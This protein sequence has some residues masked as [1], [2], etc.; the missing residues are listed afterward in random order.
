M[1]KDTRVRSFFPCCSCERV[2]HLIEELAGCR[3]DKLHR[4]INTSY[5]REIPSVFILNLAYDTCLFSGT[6][7]DRHVR[8]RRATLGPID[9]IIG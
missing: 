1:V 3:S 9:S 2:L 8:G 5:C 7:H 6:Q 4:P